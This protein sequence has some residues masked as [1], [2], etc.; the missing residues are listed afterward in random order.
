MAVLKYKTDGNVDPAGKPRV[1]FT[2]HPDDFD[3]CFEKIS[4][5]FFN[6]HS[7]AIYYKADMSERILDQDKEIELGR[8]NLFVIPVTQKLLTTPNIAMDDEVHYALEAGIPVLP[9]IMDNKVNQ[10]YSRADRF[11]ELQ[12]L[13]PY[14]LD[15]TGIPYE[16]KLKK[17]L[18][19]V[20][21]SDEM[22]TRI[23]KAFRAYAFLSYRKKDRYYAN[24]LMKLI[25]THLE[26]WDT[27]IWFDE[28]LTPGESFRMNISRKLEE[29]QVFVL[30]VTPSILEEPN[31]KPNF[32]MAEEYPTACKL[33]IPI[34]PVEMKQTDREQ[35]DLKYPHLPK[36]VSATGDLCREKLMELIPNRPVG[37]GLSV[38]ERRYLVGLAYLEGIDVE[39]DRNR[40]LELLADAADGG[41]IEAA[42]R[43]ASM[44]LEGIFVPKDLAKA[45][46]WQKKVMDLLQEKCIDAP[47]VS[48]VLDLADAIRMY[49]EIERSRTQREC[50]LESMIDFCQKAL[51]LGT[52]A[53]ER[54]NDDTKRQAL[55]SI[56]KTMRTLGILYELSGAYDM[57]KQLYMK[58]L[59]DVESL[60]QNDDEEKIPLN[61]LVWLAQ[62]HQDYGILLQKTGDSRRATDELETALKLYEKVAGYT[63]NV[64]PLV[65]NVHILLVYICSHYDNDLAARYSM[66]SVQKAQELYKKNPERHDLTYANA[67]FSHVYFLVESGSGDYAEQERLCLL[68]IDIFEKHKDDSNH[69]VM[70]TYMNALY[71][72]AGIFRRSGDHSKARQYYLRSIAVSEIVSET[73]ELQDRETIAHLFFD[74]ATSALADY[75]NPLLDE[76]RR[77]M[78]SALEMFQELALVDSKNQ[79]FIE[80]CQWVLIQL[81]K[82]AEE[83]FEEMSE[84]PELA[85]KKTEKQEVAE[86]YLQ[87]FSVG[88]AAEKMGHYPRGF[89]S[90]QEALKYL[91]RLKELDET[92]GLLH[93]SDLYDRM[94]VCCEMM[95]QYEKAFHYYEEAA[96]SAVEAVKNG[97]QGRDDLIRSLEK[98]GSFCK[99]YISDESAQYY[100]RLAAFARKYR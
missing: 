21:F 81:D 3:E 89:V 27:A 94:A 20:L 51:L 83:T 95:G 15:E 86:R 87:H 72:L 6:S 91:V 96:K 80:E 48:D 28:F 78:Q 93:F 73:A 12:Y 44:H 57:A 39:I 66:L 1:Y 77:Y 4:T 5:D 70:S 100:Y 68:G 26:C 42:R 13:S 8:S 30:L 82:I 18:K 29:S 17:Y 84:T 98:L 46:H 16:E 61:T 99:D 85:T 50:T 69:V 14:T 64:L 37:Y 97:E 36:C 23:R 55:T 56:I 10:I 45:S 79:Q 92:I 22:V 25:H 9:I 49:V 2:C 19:M 43:M 67:L 90:Y 59:L 53:A 24:E 35:L 54:L 40:G 76:A 62:T 47:Y 32:V 71:K 33:A 11:G 7:C 31:G 38:V 52:T 41:S 58:C 74:Y 34:L 65:V 75:H 60:A 63:I 88:D